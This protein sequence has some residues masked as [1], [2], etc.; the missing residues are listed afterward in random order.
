MMNTIEFDISFP[1]TPLSF[2]KAKILCGMAIVLKQSEWLTDKEHLY[3]IQTGFMEDVPI[4]ICHP[5]VADRVK[6][7]CK[8]K[9]VEVIDYTDYFNKK[10]GKS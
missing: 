10:I 7:L 2:I 6:E 3:R 9:N 4:F 5:D 8:T 1:L